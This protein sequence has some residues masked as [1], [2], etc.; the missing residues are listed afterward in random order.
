MNA[1]LFPS[2]WCLTGPGARPYSPPHLLVRHLAASRMDKGTP[3][4][5][6][7]KEKRFDSFREGQ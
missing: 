2:N 6:A 5:C 1:G 4:V 3:V 7:I